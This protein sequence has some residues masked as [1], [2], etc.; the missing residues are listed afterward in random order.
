V[1]ASAELHNLQSA[2]SH[3]GEW[4]TGEADALDSEAQAPARRSNHPSM[5]WDEFDH[6]DNF[7]FDMPK[8]VRFVRRVLRRRHQDDE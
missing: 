4:Q 6:G 8:D 2:H 5:Q 3:D 7:A 1:N